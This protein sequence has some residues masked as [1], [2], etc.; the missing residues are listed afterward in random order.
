MVLKDGNRLFK[1][2]ELYRVKNLYIGILGFM[3]I[4][5]VTGRK[6]YIEDSFYS[7]L[8]KEHNYRYQIVSRSKKD[9]QDRPLSDSIV[10]EKVLPLKEDVFVDELEPISYY[11]D[12]DTVTMKEIHNILLNKNKN[13]KVKTFKK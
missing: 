10:R 4:D 5:S 12:Q 7:A 3:G 2:E 6:I 11:T 9:N 1:G 8:K 13:P